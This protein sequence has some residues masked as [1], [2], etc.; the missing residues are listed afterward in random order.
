MAKKKDASTVEVPGGDEGGKTES[1]AWKVYSGIAAVA[2]GTI[3]RKAVERAW[4]KATGKAPP[5]DPESPSVHW[6]E[7]VAWSALS[8][9]TV[10]I[11]RLLATRRAAGTWQR[12]SVQSPTKVESADDG[13]LL[14]AVPRH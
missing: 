5:N 11:A 13:K 8:G 4:T 6:K 14:I 12:V 3:A 10:A 9:T 2:A 7:A 1:I